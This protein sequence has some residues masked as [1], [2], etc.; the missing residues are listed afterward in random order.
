MPHDSYSYKKGKPEHGNT[1]GEYYVRM[2]AEIRMRHLRAKGHPAL[3][4]SHREHVTTEE[5]NAT[6]LLS[7]GSETSLQ[8]CEPTKL[9]NFQSSVLWYFVMEAMGKLIPQ[10]KTNTSGTIL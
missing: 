2:K 5:R 10:H 1:W 7:E 6:D 9:C 3:P 8:K 4:K